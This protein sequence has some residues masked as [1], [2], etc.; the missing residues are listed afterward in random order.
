MKISKILTPQELVD[1]IYNEGSK[2]KIQQFFDLINC[3]ENGECGSRQWTT[4]RLL[5][6]GYNKKEVEKIRG[7]LV[8]SS[9]IVIKYMIHCGKLSPE[10]SGEIYCDNF[11]GWIYNAGANIKTI[12]EVEAKIKKLFKQFLQKAIK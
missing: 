2:N 3:V 4:K 1:F 10:Y 5:K 6:R 9:R 8:K 12:N 11:S 7:L